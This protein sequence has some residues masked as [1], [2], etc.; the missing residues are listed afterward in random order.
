MA[1]NK[2]AKK[3]NNNNLKNFGLGLLALLLCYG[4]GSWAIDSGSIWHYGLA[5]VSFYFFVHYT[6]LAIKG[7]LKSN[8]K[9]ETARRAKS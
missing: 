1:N 6:K 3:V 7:W 4:F 9:S 8:G 2:S 5:F